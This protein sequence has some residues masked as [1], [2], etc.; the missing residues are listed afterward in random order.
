VRRPVLLLLLIAACRD[1]PTLAG[2]FELDR[3]GRLFFVRDGHLH[4]TIDDDF[5]AHPA[6]VSPMG[7]HGPSLSRNGRA[8]AWHEGGGVVVL[9]RATGARR[10]VTPSGFV[11]ALPVW[12][13]DGGQMMVRRRNPADGTTRLVRIDPWRGTESEVPYA[14][15]ASN[16]TFDWSSEREEIVFERYESDAAGEA[17]VRVDTRTGRET[18][19]LPAREAMSYHGPQWSPDGARIVVLRRDFS[20]GPDEEVV[21]IYDRQGNQVAQLLAH[22]PSSATWSP[23]GRQVA[24]CQQA[25]VSIVQYRTEIRIWN[26]GEG[27]TYTITPPDRADCQPTWGR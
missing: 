6:Q 24:F 19:L 2:G 17:L 8:L 27:T 15:P 23:D 13:S 9:D 4:V 18:P 21:A 1:A 5:T 14:P 16:F 22:S 20:I 26:I 12:S 11:D 7:A 3:N 25:L 10:T